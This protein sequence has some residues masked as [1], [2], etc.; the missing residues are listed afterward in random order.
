MIIDFIQKMFKHSFSKEWYETYW[1]FDLHGTIIKPT[2][3]G[4]EVIYYPHAKET[5]QILTKRPD[6]KMILWTSSFPNEIKEYIDRF[7]KDGI[8]FDAV[9]EN[10]GISSKNG[11]FGYYENKFYFNVL[12]DDKAG[13]DPNTEWYQVLDFLLTCDSINFLPNPTWTTKY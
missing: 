7:E 10:P 3:K 9:N 13:F 1:A 5:L 2:Y 11:N 8:H 4:T 12:F 6:I